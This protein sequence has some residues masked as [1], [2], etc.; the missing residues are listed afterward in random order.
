MTPLLKSCVYIA[1]SFGV[2]ALSGCGGSQLPSGAIGTAAPNY[3]DA[4]AQ[5]KVFQYT[6]KPQRF[7]VPSSVT[8]ITVV[9]DGAAGAGPPYT[10]EPPG[11]RGGRVYAV[12][13]VLPNETLYVYVGGTGDGPS[14][15]FNGGASGEYMSYG[16]SFGGGGASDIREG[17]QS[18]SDRIVVAGAGGGAGGD[19][20]S[21][22]AGAGGDGGTH[23]G[24]GGGGGEYNGSGEGGRGGTQIRGGAGGDPGR[25][26]YGY[27]QHGTPG[28]FGLGGAGGGIG[29]TSSC[30]P[31]GGGGGGGGGYYGGGGGGS[32]GA[33]TSHQGNGGGAGGGSS[34]VEKSAR[35]VRMYR[36]WKDAT[37][38]G[39]I[40]I[41]WSQAKPSA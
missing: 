4:V 3:I 21:G 19:A 20:Y 30:E 37:D 25:G 35:G 15:G 26:S 27:G 7:K 8:Q 9:V 39:S 5:S 38:N 2:V 22:G 29:C 41:K 36:G 6:G 24:G 10:Y 28:A 17:G 18:L 16:G 33:Q 23:I 11:G 32:G 1:L 13:A 34:Y 12:L 40:T 31:G 14:G